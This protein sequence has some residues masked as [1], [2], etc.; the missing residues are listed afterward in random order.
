MTKSKE[1][2]EQVRIKELT[3]RYSKVIVSSIKPETHVRPV[4]ADFLGEKQQRTV[5][6]A[7]PSYLKPT[8]ML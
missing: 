7:T 4:V 3:E 5:Q 8:K 2:L 1:W 6:I